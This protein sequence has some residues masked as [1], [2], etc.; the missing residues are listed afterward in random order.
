[1][2]YGEGIIS[3][4]YSWVWHPSNSEETLSDW[5]AGLVVVIVLA[6][7]WSTVVKQLSA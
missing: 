7:L 1:M 4:I 2:N 6:F 3:K 5:G